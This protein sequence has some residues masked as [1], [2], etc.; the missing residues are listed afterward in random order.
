MSVNLNTLLLLDALAPCGVVLPIE[1]SAALDT[2]LGLKQR[3]LGVKQFVLWGRLST[4]S[5]AD[6]YVARAFNGARVVDGKIAGNAGNK[7]Y[8]SQDGV[9][10]LDLE[11]VPAGSKAPQLDCWLSGDPSHQ[12]TVYEEQ[13]LPAP[14]PA[15]EGEAAPPAPEP[16]PP[17]EHPV[18][19]L[20]YMMHT[21][22]GINAETG[23]SPVGMIIQDAD[24]NFVANPLFS[25]KYPDQLSSYRGLGGN[26]GAA[27]PGSWGI[28]HDSFKN[29][30]TLRSFLYPGFFAYYSGKS[31]DMGNLYFGTG[32]KNKDLAFTV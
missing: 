1:V 28:V 5:G 14:P 20:A 30:T 29:L 22:N 10:W 17:L 4:L 13:P 3:E 9:S 18:S 7:F 26:L 8:Y 11:P 19:E 12:F 31:N 21:I 25:M 32:L 15:V 23:C 16:L 24:G 6:Y 2:S 27:V